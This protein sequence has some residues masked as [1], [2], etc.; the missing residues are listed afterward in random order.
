MNIPLGPVLFRQPLPPAGAAA[1]AA[2]NDNEADQVEGCLLH[3]ALRHFAEHGLG[4]AELA[5]QR[6]EKAFFAG[7]GKEYRHWLDICRAL[8]RRM[9]DA[10][11]FRR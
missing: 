7:N 11:R 5:Q 6:A 3:A 2:A 9:A 8:D 10:V 4:A 1:F